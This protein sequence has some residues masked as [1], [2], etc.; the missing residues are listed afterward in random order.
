M[1]PS[2]VDFSKIRALSFDLDDTL[3][4]IRPVIERAEKTLQAWLVSE[5][6]NTAEFFEHNNVLDLRTAV[7][8]DFPNHYYDLTFLRKECIRRI[9][10]EGGYGEDGVEPAFS[11]FKHERDGVEL[12]DDAVAFFE[13]HN[14]EHLPCVAL[15]NGNASLERTPLT[16]SFEF[17]LN[18]VAVKAPKPEPEMFEEALRRLEIEPH[19]LL[20]IGDCIEADVGGA[21]QLGIPSVWVNRMS[22]PWLSHFAKPG[23]VINN[24]NQLQPWLGSGDPTS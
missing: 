6:P 1:S 2:P 15:T 24:L 11:V 14:R 12:F 22:R 8:S 5:F 23:L 13:Q 10:K 17:Y 9:L 7:F 16:D 3:W 18:A 21:S 19:E 4:P 20:H